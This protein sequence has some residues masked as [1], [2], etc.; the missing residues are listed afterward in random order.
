M[1]TPPQPTW[2]NF[3]RQ[4]P[5]SLPTLHRASTRSA[6]AH[7]ARA[8]KQPPRP[9]HVGSTRGAPAPTSHAPTARDRLVGISRHVGRP[10][11]GELA[12]APHTGAA[13]WGD[14]AWFPASRGGHS[15]AGPGLLE[16]AQLRRT[17]ARRAYDAACCHSP[18]QGLRGRESGA[19]LPASHVA[20]E[21]RQRAGP[22]ARPG[23]S[24]P[25][26]KRQ[27]AGPLARAGASCPARKRCRFARKPRGLR[28]SP[29]V[30]AGRKGSAG[31][32]RARGLRG[33]RESGAA[34]PASHV[35][36][37]LGVPCRE[38]GATVGRRSGVLRAGAT[39]SGHSM[40]SWRASRSGPMPMRRRTCACSRPA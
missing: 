17:P 2:R 28:E 21:K 26:G 14:V 20:W 40:S 12:D 5:Q 4:P 7:R 13:C 36:C 6:T 37:G 33:L 34:L 22:L 39:T 16:S 23:A 30:K 35:A 38:T 9:P 18:G 27:R 10:G 19:A 25:A 1:L 24:C 11:P 8:R 32:S 29:S 15:H 31:H 3:P